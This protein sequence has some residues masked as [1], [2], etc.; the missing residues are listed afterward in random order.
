LFTPL[1]NHKRALKTG[2][3]ATS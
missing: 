1:Y 2:Q 3:S